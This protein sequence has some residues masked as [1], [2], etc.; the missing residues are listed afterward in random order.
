MT[1]TSNIYAEKIFAEHPI[2]LWLLDDTADYVNLV[3]TSEQDIS[4]SFWTKPSGVTATTLDPST[5]Y[6]PFSD[7]TINQL[8]V[9]TPPSGSVT[10]RVESGVID[11]FGNIKYELKTFNFS[12]YVYST[13]SSDYLESVAIGYSYESSPGTW[14]DVKETFTLLPVQQWTLLSKTFDIPIYVDF[15][16]FIEFKVKY[17]L[18]PFYDFYVNGMTVGQ[19][20]E[21]FNAVSL[22]VQPISL[23]STIALPASLATVAYSY[24]LEENNGYYLIN[25]KFLTAQNTSI[26]MVFGAENITTIR[27]N[28]DSLGNPLPSLIVPGKGFLNKIGKYQEYTVEFWARIN[29][30]SSEPLRIFGPIASNDGIYVEDGFITLSIGGVAGSHF[31]GRWYRPMLIH[32]IV[33]QNSA[34]L[35]INGEEVVTLN[36]VT[37]DLTLPSEYSLL[38]KNQNWLGFYGY[39]NVYPFEIDCVSIYSYQIPTLVAKR[40]YAYGQAVGS[41]ENINTAFGGTTAFVDYGFA[42]YSVNYNYPDFAKWEQ[43][44][45]ENLTATSQT[46]QTPDY[47]LPNI[48][49]GSY[50]LEQFYSDNQTLQDP[51]DQYKFIK[52]RPTTGTRD[53]SSEKSYINFPKF[54]FLITPIT[55]FY[56]VFKVDGSNYNDQ[57]LFKLYNK[58]TGNSLV[59]KKDKHAIVE[60]GPDVDVISFYL[61]FGGIQ[62]PD[63][64]LKQYDV[65]DLVSVGLD[66]KKLSEYYGGNVASFFGTLNGLE[67]YVGGDN[68]GI[69]TFEGE[70]YNVGFCSERNASGISQHFGDDGIMLTTSGTDLVDHLA[71]YS[72]LIA[73]NYGVFD[74]DI[75]VSGYWQ[76]YLPLSY[77]AKFVKDNNGK[78]YYDL[79]L[80]QFNIGYPANSLLTTE[81]SQSI[82][83]YNDVVPTENYDTYQQ[84]LNYTLSLIPALDYESF[85]DNISTTYNFN[86]Q[87]SAVKSYI[88]FQYVDEGANKIPSTF[89]QLTPANES[90][91]LDV[92]DYNDWEV[93][94][95][96]VID[97]NIIYPRKDIDFNDIAIVISLEFS[98]RNIIHK[99]VKVN[100][101]QIA[102]LALNENS[103]NP[104]GTRFGK[105]IFPYKK[106]G[107]YFNYKDNNP[108]SIYKQ[109]TPYLYLTRDSGIEIRGNIDPTENRGISVPM[110]EQLSDDYSVNAFQIW[111]R[112]DKDQFPQ[113]TTQIFEIVGKDKTIK[114][115]MR[116]TDLTRNRAVIFAVVDNDVNNFIDLSYYVNGK[117][118][119]TPTITTKQWVS[120]GIS[121]DQSLDLD[122]YV[123]SIN[124]TGPLVYN[125]ISY[126][127]TNNLAN[128]EVITTRQ[129]SFIGTEDWQYWK[130]DFT[131]RSVYATYSNLEFGLNPSK[132]YAAYIGTNKIIID[133]EMGL[134]LNSDKIVSHSGVSWNRRYE[135]PV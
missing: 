111:M 86:T 127:K 1:V 112:Y 135:I 129:W 69:Q 98:A 99:K 70:I 85:S 114:F 30:D 105:Q 79:D 66:I 37:S 51:L 53:W 19:W 120:I 5:T 121:L 123:G 40:R 113:E 124:L 87:N 16:I 39:D 107:F 41:P 71:S 88:T 73:E 25:E 84:L 125:N 44:A 97:N 38:N 61:D 94:R 119:L 109:S 45:I 92:S 100:D 65:N 32:I 14:T 33:T 76:D 116:Y 108:I 72:L 118:V 126:Y 62:T 20:S 36:I 6:A 75:G 80:L 103:F 91:L 96:E 17:S 83:Y 58:I 34:K 64:I 117:P 102:S 67:L 122:N 11:N 77:F 46:L 104:I 131:W 18:I 21:E 55:A 15:K 60:S 63:F 7:V 50:T 52:L 89:T 82:W 93:R 56:G 130:E 54:D 29:C 3:T 35:L 106:V 78:T 47:A 8:T 133:D 90:R 28:V 31:V 128:I 10:K 12:T 81:T 4:Q 22:G 42:N 68:S 43:G 9:T 24:G 95:F 59:I 49:T 13:V 48:F 74:L 23:P 110:N 27:T 57:V 26:P 2:A 134:G 132:I 115:Y 101:L